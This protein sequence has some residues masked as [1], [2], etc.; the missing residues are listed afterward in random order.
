VCLGATSICWAGACAL[1]VAFVCYQPMSKQ[2]VCGAIRY[3]TIRYD[4]AI[5]ARTDPTLTGEEGIEYR[6]SSI[7]KTIPKEKKNRPLV[8]DRT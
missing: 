5:S 1:V 4:T 7:G 8:A 2:K 3:D 6:V